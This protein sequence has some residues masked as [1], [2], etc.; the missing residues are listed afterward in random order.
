MI[1]HLLH[2]DLWKWHADQYKAA[3]LNSPEKALAFADS[4]FY[5]KHSYKSW[6]LYLLQVVNVNSRS[7]CLESPLRSSMGQDRLNGLVML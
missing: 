3:E 5:F 2:L 1:F 4:D 6:L 7:V